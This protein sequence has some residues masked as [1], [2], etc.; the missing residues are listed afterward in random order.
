MPPVK[1][2]F[3]SGFEEKLAKEIEDAGLPVKY[4]TLRPQLRLA[5]EEQHLLP[6][7]EITTAGGKHF[8]IE[9]KGYF[10]TQA[11]NKMILVRQQHPDL[12]IR[13]VFQNANSPI[14]RG[15]PTSYRAWAERHGFPY[16]HKSI[17]PEW[18]TEEGDVSDEPEQEDPGSSE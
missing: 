3:R 17:P 8:L 9:A 16:A 4:E 10:D 7:F 6:D 1:T 5:G 11:R 13:L 14:Y 15:S 2:R 18:L 12:D